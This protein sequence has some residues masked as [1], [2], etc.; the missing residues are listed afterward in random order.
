[1]SNLREMGLLGGRELEVL[2][3]NRT[4]RMCR[5]FMRDSRG[6]FFLGYCHPMA[7]YPGASLGSA[8]IICVHY[9][10]GLIGAAVRTDLDSLAHAMSNYTE[11]EEELDEQALDDRDLTIVDWSLTEDWDEPGLPHALWY[12]DGQG[13]RWVGWPGDP[14]PEPP[15]EM[16]ESVDGRF[17]EGLPVT[18]AALRLITHQVPVDEWPVALWPSASGDEVYFVSHSSPL[19]AV[20]VPVQLSDVPGSVE[21]VVSAVIEESG[22][23]KL[24]SGGDLGLVLGSEAKWTVNLLDPPK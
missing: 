4:M 11:C 17:C 2:G 9:M 13:I 7:V 15:F 5:A 8:N 6:R 1:M 23:R 22:A 3:I 14:I 20:A 21:R 12:Q 19:R 16:G 18:S 24:E 10:V